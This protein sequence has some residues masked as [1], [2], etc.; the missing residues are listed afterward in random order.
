MDKDDKQD[1]KHPLLW[2]QAKWGKGQPQ[3]PEEQPWAVRKA[4]M[5]QAQEA[6]L[7]QHLEACGADPRSID[8]VLKGVEDRAAMLG[9]RSWAASGKIFCVLYGDRGSGKTTAAVHALKLARR[10]MH[11]YDENKNVVSS[12]AY[13]ASDGMFVRAADLSSATFTDEGKA[14]LSKAKRAPLLVIDDLGVERM[15]NAGIWAEA[16]DL[17]T[18]VRYARRLRTIITTNLD[19][20]AF[21]QRYGERIFDR[22]CEHE[23]MVVACGNGSMRRIA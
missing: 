21:S 20:V 19:E 4:Q 14:R 1:P 9:L 8:L 23:G 17:L 5:E 15:D 7:A 22:I 12:W 13:C 3:E 6:R 10:S 18:D 16:F 11:F 2:F